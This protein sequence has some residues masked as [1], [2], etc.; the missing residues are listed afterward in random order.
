LGQ[1][2]GT[3]L[4]EETIENARHNWYVMAPLSPQAG[5]SAQLMVWEANRLPL[6]DNSVYAV[7]SILDAN[8]IAALTSVQLKEIF[9][10]LRPERRAAFLVPETGQLQQ[11]LSAEGWHI[12][13]EVT[14][15]EPQV[16]VLVVA[17]RSN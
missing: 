11:I 3:D 12:L 6:R 2:I 1:A 10:V 4:S 15:G 17:N 5:S 16:G 7:A 9:R 13:Q 8:Q 14:V